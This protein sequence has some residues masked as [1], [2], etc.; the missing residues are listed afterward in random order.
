MILFSF[1]LLSFFC[2][3][4][5]FVIRKGKDC[6]IYLAINLKING[7]PLSSQHIFE[8]TNSYDFDL[9][10]S[11][12]NNRHSLIKTPEEQIFAPLKHDD[13]DMQELDEMQSEFYSPD[14]GILYGIYL[15]SSKVILKA[16][17]PFDLKEP[18]YITVKKISPEN[19][20]EYRVTT[21]AL[22]LNPIK[23]IY[24]FK[25]C[26]LDK[27]D[28]QSKIFL[29]EIYKGYINRQSSVMKLNQNF[30]KRL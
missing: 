14:G 10:K 1:H 9:A 20:L 2:N 17:F 5:L 15:T 22:K 8:I 19:T 21:R 11:V 29:P 28:E 4:L 6:N 12:S 3:N 24:R 27:V 30:F 23:N 16:K 26:K 18:F 7:E 25:L 13:I